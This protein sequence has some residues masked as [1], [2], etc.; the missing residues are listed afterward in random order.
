[1]TGGERL[2][3]LNADDY[4]PARYARTKLLQQSGFEVIEAQTGREA[5]EQAI[6]TRPHVVLLDVKLPDLD[7]YEVCRRLKAHPI[8]AVI[9]VLHLSAA[10]RDPR[11]SRARPRRR[12]RWL[13]G[14]AGGAGDPAG[15]GPLGGAGP[16]GRGGAAGG[17]AP[18]AADVRRHLRRRV[19]PRPR[20]ADPAPQRGVRPAGRRGRG[21]GRRATAPRWPAGVLGRP[22]SELRT[23]LIPEARAVRE[24]AIGGRWLQ[25][26]SET[27]R[28]EDGRPE[29]GW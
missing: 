3:V 2:R 23:L 19:R 5:L 26:V 15:D 18:V 22:A 27:V 9:P 20:G 16:P 24:F 28:D 21:A 10:H 6:A 25:L 14:R 1:M 8:T 13:P 12:R 29:G 17:R 4:G 7:G 11:R